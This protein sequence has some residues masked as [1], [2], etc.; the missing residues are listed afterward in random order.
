MPPFVNKDSPAIVTAIFKTSD[1]ERSLQLISTVQQ[2]APDS[3]L[4]IFDLIPEEKRDKPTDPNSFQTSDTVSDF[5]SV[6]LFIAGKL[7]MN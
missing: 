1:Y 5:L 6:I 2:F 3:H 4:A 7:R